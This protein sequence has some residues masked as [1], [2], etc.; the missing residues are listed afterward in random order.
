MPGPALLVSPLLGGFPHG[1][2]TR[3]GGL[4]RGPFRSLNLGAEVGD[5][6]ERVVQN[7]ER[8]EQATGLAFARVRQVHGCRVV[9]AGSGTG[10]TE[11]AD[12]VTTAVPGVAACVS[13]ADCAPVLIADPR[14]G[15]VA[16]IHAGWRGTIARA[17]AQGVR[18]LVDRHGARPADLRSAPASARVASRSPG[19]WL[20][21]SGT[22]SGQSPETP[23]KTA[24][25]PTSGGP[26]RRSS[27]RPDWPAGASTSWRVAP[28]ARRASS[29]PT[30]AIRGA[31]GGTWPSSPRFLD[32]HA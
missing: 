29:S 23:G 15:A 3:E 18:A 10:P 19:T 2:T 11:E 28:P 13:V 8:L 4:S 20:H 22:N 6:P 31:P 16:A 9:E 17:A 1:F 30:G 24:L 5:D 7:W 25:E 14:S 26:T 32:C 12:A 27:G 21:G